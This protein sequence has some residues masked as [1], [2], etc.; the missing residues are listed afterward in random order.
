MSLPVA[1][2]RLNLVRAPEQLDAVLAKAPRGLVLSLGVVD[3]RNAWKTDLEK[4][5]AKIEPVIARRGTDHVQVAP[6]CSLLHSPIDLELETRLDPEVFDLAKTGAAMIQIDE[7]ALRRSALD[8]P[9]LRS[10]DPE[11]GG[12]PPCA[13]QYGRSG[14]RNPRNGALKP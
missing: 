13:R 14:A 12:S 4:V 9:G 8:Q 10:Q 1:G 5:I 3:G 6:S 11:M 2:L 7:A